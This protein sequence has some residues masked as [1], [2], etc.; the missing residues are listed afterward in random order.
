MIATYS[1]PLANIKEKVAVEA[2]NDGMFL[3]NFIKLSIQM[4]G[5]KPDG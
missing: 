5:L 2:M 3:T 4:F 1:L